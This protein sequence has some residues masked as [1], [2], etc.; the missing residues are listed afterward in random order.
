LKE[1][2]LQALKEMGDHSKV[3]TIRRVSG[4]D[5]NEAYYVQTHSGQ[6]F[7]KYQRNIPKGF[8][9]KEASGLER[10]KE[11]G[12]ISVPQVF[13]VHENGRE[14]ILV[15]EW[16]DGEKQA[17][18]EEE[19]GRG[20]ARLHQTTA[21]KFGL[22]EDSFIGTLPQSNNWYDHWID[23][24]RE[25][26]LLP[27]MKLAE[28]LGRMPFH[29]KQKLTKVIES[30]EKWLPLE[31]RPSL[32]HGDLWGGNWL[33]GPNGTPYLIDPSVFYGHYEFELAFTELFGGFS[34]AFYRSYQEIQP[35]SAEYEERKPLYQLYYL[36]VH[37]NM[38]GEIYGP[39]VDRIVTRYS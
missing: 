9:Q 26:R 13:Y 36:L 33:T 39:S 6:F 22:D 38:F 8:F 18:T 14:G 3:K 32:L 29:R 35:V 23:Y 27:Q 15:M 11:T 4:G 17:H 28:K 30:L 1:L 25:C 10:I 5:I 20:V 19:L 7:V 12:A 37:L 2:L 21:E 31:C 34:D 24:Y 16:I